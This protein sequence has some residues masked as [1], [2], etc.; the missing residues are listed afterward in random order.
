M[1]LITSWLVITLISP[2]FFP[3]D[4][5][6]TSSFSTNMILLTCLRQTSA[7]HLPNARKRVQSCT[8]QL[9]VIPPSQCISSQAEESSTCLWAGVGAKYFNNRSLTVRNRASEQEVQQGLV[10]DAVGAAVRGDRLMPVLHEE[11]SENISNRTTKN[12]KN[13]E[14]EKWAKATWYIDQRGW[15]KGIRRVPT[16][17]PADTRCVWAVGRKEKTSLYSHRQHDLRCGNPA[18]NVEFMHSFHKFM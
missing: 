8:A 11:V 3:V 7:A 16:Y 1:A 6:M 10:R 5:I 14:S 4:G 13:A 15:G 18:E 9:Q 12:T 2:I 17:A